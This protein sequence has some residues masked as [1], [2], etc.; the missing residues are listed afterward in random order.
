[1]PLIKPCIV[2]VPAALDS[3][4]VSIFVVILVE[5]TNTHSEA[6][7]IVLMYHNE[8]LPFCL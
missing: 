1:M 3:T 5:V 7:V 4:A 8:T 2:K 6:E